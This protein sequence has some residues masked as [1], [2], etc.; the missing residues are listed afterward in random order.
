MHIA[1]EQDDTSHSYKAF[2]FARFRINSFCQLTPFLV[3]NVEILNDDIQNY[4]TEILGVFKDAIKVEYYNI[5]DLY[6]K[7]F[8]STKC[9]FKIENRWRRQHSEIILLSFKQNL[10]SIQ[11]KN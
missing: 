7:L 5:L 9:S 1:K 6:G 4:D 8:T 2:A 10:N 11:P 3:A